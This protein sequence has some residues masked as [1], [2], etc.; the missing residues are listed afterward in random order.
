MTVH[1]EV[2]HVKL[3]LEWSEQRDELLDKG[4]ILHDKGR[5]ELKHQIGNFNQIIITFNGDYKPQPT[6]NM[7]SLSLSSFR[8]EELTRTDSLRL[9]FL[10]LYPH[11]TTT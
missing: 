4:D 1:F 9:T 11:R 3:G 2:K 8:E 7:S 10:S 6:S 5:D